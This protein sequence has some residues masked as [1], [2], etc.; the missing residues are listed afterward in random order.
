MERH[1]PESDG[2]VFRSLRQLALERFCQRVL[3]EV[4]QRIA[5]VGG[6][7]HERYRAVFR[8]LQERDEELAAA[9]NDPRRSTALVQLAR[10]QA[11]GLLTEEEFARFSDEARAAVQLLL[12]MWQA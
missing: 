8:L 7:G 9:F 1:F 3:D 5:E 11:A 2:R 12:E 10:M 6:S 4:G